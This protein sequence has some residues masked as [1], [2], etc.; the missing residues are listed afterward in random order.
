MSSTKDRLSQLVDE[1]LDLGSN[2]DFDAPLRDTGMSSV[3]AVA[4]FKVVSDEFSLSLEPDDCLQFT[5]L[6]V[7]ANF[8]DA[9]AGT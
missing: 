9:R 4:F 1:H 2:P 7:L 5:T 6:G 3:E 8:I